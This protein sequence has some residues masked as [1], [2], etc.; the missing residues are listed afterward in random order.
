[1]PRAA[2][3]SAL[4][5]VAVDARFL[6]AGGVAGLRAEAARAGADGAG[7]FFVSRG[8]LGDPFVMAAALSLSV[9]RGLVGVRLGLSEDGRHP[10]ILAREVT[11]LDL[12]CGGRSVLCFTPPFDGRLAEAIALCRAL[13]REG[14]ADSAG[15]HFPVHA[16]VNR[17]R[18]ARDG[19]PLV[20]LDLTGGAAPPGVLSDAADL[21]VRGT[22]DAAV[23]RVERA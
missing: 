13:W 6:Q 1:M 22:E 12:V 16:A 18:P 8:T 10:A 23:G 15:P 4:V 2:P 3:A 9:P 11:C 7:G 17:P 21:L 5:C 19:S 14:E 20:A